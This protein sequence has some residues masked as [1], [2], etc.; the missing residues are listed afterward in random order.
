MKDSS[1]ACYFSPKFL[2]FISYTRSKKL[3]ENSLSDFGN[4]FGHPAPCHWVFQCH[5]P[6][7]PQKKLLQSLVHWLRKFISPLASFRPLDPSQIPAPLSSQVLRVGAID[8]DSDPATPQSTAAICPTDHGEDLRQ[9]V[10]MF[11]PAVPPI[12]PLAIWPSSLGQGNGSP[13]FRL[14]QFY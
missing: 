7:T 11:G 1:N 9:Q 6:G 2:D 8:L 5:W 4:A 12:K 3:R 13:P 14:S 10:T